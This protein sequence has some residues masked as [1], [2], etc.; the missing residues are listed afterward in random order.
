[1]GWK[2]SPIAQEIVEYGKFFFEECAKK[3]NEGKKLNVY[4]SAYRVID[5]F[6][7]LINE[8]LYVNDGA[9]GLILGE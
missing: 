9:K 7:G 6:D 2:T 5:E 1:M 8:N 3:D 4:D